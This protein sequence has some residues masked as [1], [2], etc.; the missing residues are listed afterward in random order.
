MPLRVTAQDAEPITEITQTTTPAKTGLTATPDSIE[1]KQTD[2]GKVI[3]IQLKNNTDKDMPLIASELSV[4]VESGGKTTLQTEKGAITSISDQNFE[5][6]Q[7]RFTVS[8]QSEYIFK[9]RIKL[10]AEAKDNIFP[11]VAFEETTGNAGT[12]GSGNY[13]AYV[14]VLIPN[15][16]E[17]LSM[18]GNLIL[19]GSNPRVI[20]APDLSIYAVVS[21]DG[22]RY[23]Y[24]AG[25]VKVSKGG[26]VLFE[27]DITED[28][29]AIL[30][31]GD[32]KSTTLEWQNTLSP[33]SALGEYTVELELTPE[34]SSNLFTARIQYF[35]FPAEIIL[36]AIPVIAGILVLF[37]GGN[38][39]LKRRKRAEEMTQESPQEETSV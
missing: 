17:K 34:D 24:P 11:A 10:S 32:E 20:F 16:N 31:P 9:F 5:I 26:E 22:K 35:Y 7:S 23:F 4:K 14:P 25:K 33:F 8:A 13:L 2:F 21:N 29:K 28:L 36:Y 19:N 30:L 12:I 37:V 15:F 18:D 1:L 39:F 6:N 3:Q 38:Y 27:K